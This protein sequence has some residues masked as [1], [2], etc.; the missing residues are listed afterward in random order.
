[1][2][3][4]RP[5]LALLGA[6]TAGA[7]VL[8]NQ[9]FDDDTSTTGASVSA[10]TSSSSSTSTSTS[11][12]T[13]ASATS[14]G[15]GGS[16][17]NGST[18]SSTAAATGTSG[19]TGA[20]A[21]PTRLHNYVDG[22]CENG[23]YCINQQTNEPVPARIVAFEC[24]TSPLP[25]PFQ[26]TRVGADI[27]ARVGTPTPSLTVFRF[28]AQGMKIDPMSIDFEVLA[29]VNQDGHVDFPL[30]PPIIVDVADFCV[31]IEGG[32]TMN[33]TFAPAIMKD[34]PTPGPSFVEMDGG[35]NCTHNFK[36]LSAVYGTDA[37]RYC[38]DVDVA[39]I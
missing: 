21:E 34:S 2:T 29:P 14:T 5:V 10:S 19:T 9:S 33:T 6:L 7:C 26:I 38:I 3:G 32:D 17:S 1:M 28:D 24:Y 30:D 39:P 27:K 13:A 12:A 25:P 8:D 15:D 11:S 37:A 20:N 4:L 16:G 22:L 35:P 18:S 23:I 36:P 31:S